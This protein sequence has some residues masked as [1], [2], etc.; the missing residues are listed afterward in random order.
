MTSRCICIH[1]NCARE[2]RWVTNHQQQKLQLCLWLSHQAWLSIKM[3]QCWRKSSLTATAS[4]LHSEKENSSFKRYCKGKNYLLYLS[5]TS[6]YWQS[7]EGERSFLSNRIFDINFYVRIFFPVHPWLCAV[8]SPEVNPGKGL[9][10]LPV[11]SH[12]CLPPQKKQL[13]CPTRPMASED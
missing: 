3:L 12:R 13:N 9:S 5:E 2:T 11:P 8:G 1:I 10:D 4:V 6:L 7:I